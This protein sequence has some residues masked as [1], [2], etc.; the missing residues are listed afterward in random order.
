MRSHGKHNWEKYGG[1]EETVLLNTW[2]KGHI[3]KTCACRCDSL[4]GV[5][6]VIRGEDL[7]FWMFGCREGDT[8]ELKAAFCKGIWG[9][10]SSD[11]IVCLYLCVAVQRQSSQDLANCP[12]TNPVRVYVTVLP[13][14][15]VED[16]QPMGNSLMAIQL[17]CGPLINLLAD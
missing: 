17:I 15:M 3:K 7:Q 9:G 16:P 13:N 6:K 10:S 8:T 14:P 1:G 11:L 4:R 12:E 5:Q 2:S